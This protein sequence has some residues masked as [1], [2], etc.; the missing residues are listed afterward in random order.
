MPFVGLAKMIPS[1]SRLSRASS[2]SI[3]PLR[4][5]STK[6]VWVCAIPSMCGGG[7]ILV[8]RAPFDQTHPHKQRARAL[9][10]GICV[11]PWMSPMQTIVRTLEGREC[12][13][14]RRFFSL[15][16]QRQT[17]SGVCKVRGWEQH[18]PRSCND[19]LHFLPVLLL[20][21][22]YLTPLSAEPVTIM[23]SCEREFQGYFFG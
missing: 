9:E 3:P 16:Q 5:A 13:K 4:V 7:G 22:Q 21:P 19:K 10:W 20:F 8:R 6:R 11:R 12:H 14:R 17:D 2:H 18:Q 23:V 1:S 15:E